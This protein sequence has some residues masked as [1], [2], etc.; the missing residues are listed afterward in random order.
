MLT[1][2]QNTDA[3]RYRRQ[4]RRFPMLAADEEARLAKRWREHS[5]QEAVHKLV[6]S[7]LRLVV[8]VARSYG[9]YGFPFSELIS[10]GNIGL[11]EAAKR[12]DSEKGVRLSTYAVWWISAAMQDYILRSWS[13]VKMG[14]RRSERTLFFNLRKLKNRIGVQ[15]EGDMHPDQVK[16]IAKHLEVGEHD[17]VEMNR[18]LGGD[19]SLNVSMRG[20]EHSIEWQDRLADE[21]PHQEALLAQNDEFNRRYQAL[22]EALTTLGDRERHVFEMRR[23]VDEPLSLEV[24]ALKFGVSRERVRQIEARAFEKICRAVRGVCS[25]KGGA[26]QQIAAMGVSSGSIRTTKSEAARPDMQMA[27]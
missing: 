6:T 9:G 10:E 27:G 22:S 3:I 13:L 23:L 20:E 18:R 11:M 5:D 24:L 8:A 15:Q 19:A 14:T 4:L 12:F 26:S 7:H 1:S 25:R 17:V 16:F 21:R 2:R